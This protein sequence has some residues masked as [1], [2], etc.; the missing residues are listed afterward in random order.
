MNCHRMTSRTIAARALIL[1][2]ARS[3]SG[4]ELISITDYETGQAVP[5]SSVRG[6]LPRDLT[7]SRIVRFVDQNDPAS[8]AIC[9]MQAREWAAGMGF[10]PHPTLL[11]RN[12]HAFDATSIAVLATVDHE[13]LDPRPTNVQYHKFVDDE[14]PV[15]DS[16]PFDAIIWCDEH[17][18]DGRQSRVED[19]NGRTVYGVRERA[20]RG[21]MTA[22]PGLCRFSVDLSVPDREILAKGAAF[23]CNS[24]PTGSIELDL[25]RVVLQPSK[26]PSQVGY[27]L[28]SAIVR[29]LGDTRYRLFVEALVT[30]PQKLKAEALVE[31]IRVRGYEEI[32]S[33]AMPRVPQVMEE[34]LYDVLIAC[35]E[36]PDF[37]KYG[38]YLSAR[39]F[40]SAEAISRLA[41]LRFHGT[42]HRE[43]GGALS[44]L[45]TLA[46]VLLR[47]DQDRAI[48]DAIH[49]EGMDDSYCS[50]LFHAL[51]ALGDDGLS[52]LAHTYEL[53]LEFVRSQMK[54]E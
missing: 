1:A 6:K 19:H 42:T 7:I 30:D 3:T 37:G 45:L 46:G 41:R 16:S 27:T 28:V 18:A 33:P 13:H 20:L 38:A 50:A 5:T 44:A 24:E 10:I 29:A 26:L 54:D 35:N 15:F 47:A 8:V 9:D 51:S 12:A 32:A 22:F 48:R 23:R 49:N 43:N 52:E 4:Y 34:Y 36:D 40:G 11:V 2:Y 53:D 39:R 17:L 31:R 21:A 25:L 14:A